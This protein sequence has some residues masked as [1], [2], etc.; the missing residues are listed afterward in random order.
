MTPVPGTATSDPKSAPIVVISETRLPSASPQTTCVVPLR[1]PAEVGRNP[2]H[3]AAGTIGRGAARSR[4]IA[5]ARDR[6][7]LRA[8]ELLDRVLS[9]VGI[10]RIRRTVHERVAH[11]LG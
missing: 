4:L 6:G 8:A 2:S 3:G 7:E 5:A 10:A 9:E 1:P 11:R